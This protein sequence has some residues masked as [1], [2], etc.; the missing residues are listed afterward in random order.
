VT[1]YGQWHCFQEDMAIPVGRDL[2]WMQTTVINGLLGGLDH[3]RRGRCP[4][5]SE[6]PGTCMFDLRLPIN[7]S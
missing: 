2:T 3:R 7:G 4:F 5:P 1:I 6:L